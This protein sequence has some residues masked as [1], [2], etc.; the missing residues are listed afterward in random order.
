MVAARAAVMAWGVVAAARSAAQDVLPFPDPPL[1]SVAR[2]RLQ[3]SKPVWPEAPRRLAADAPNIVVILLDDVGFGVAETFG[4][5]VRT[6]T[7]SRLA[8]PFILPVSRVSRAA[9]APARPF[10][11][12]TILRSSYPLAN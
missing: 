2:E 1:P 11:T 9:G 7:L 12:R 10:A 8:H 5:E 3:D 4:G 6:P